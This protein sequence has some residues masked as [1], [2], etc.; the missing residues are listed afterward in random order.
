M[1]KHILDALHRGLLACGAGPVVLAII[2]II[3][4]S[5]GKPETLTLAEAAKGILTITELA[6][7]SGALTVLYQIER[8]PLF[9]A[10]LIH[11]MV[12]YL[13]YL[14][15]YLVNGWLQK[16]SYPLIVFTVCFILGYAAIWAIIYFTSVKKVKKLNKAIKNEV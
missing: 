11:G 13:D 9:P 2:Y 6:F 16:G 4:A 3:L 12:L 5:N 7:V 15:V 8:L 10:L 14:S 1:K